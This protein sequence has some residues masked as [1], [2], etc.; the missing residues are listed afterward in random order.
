[1]HEVLA[2][3]LVQSIEHRHLEVLHGAVELVL[4]DVHSLVAVGEQLIDEQFMDRGA[5]LAFRPHL[6]DRHP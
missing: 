4:T 1:M 5:W 2:S 6:I 3:D